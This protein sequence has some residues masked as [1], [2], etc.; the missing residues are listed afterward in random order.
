MHREA[1]SLRRDAPIK[2]IWEDRHRQWLPQ[3]TFGVKPIWKPRCVLTAITI[4]ETVRSGRKNFITV[5]HQLVE[6]PRIENPDGGILIRF[7]VHQREIQGNL[8]V[9]C[10]VEKTSRR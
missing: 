9:F 7:T 1:R 3:A 10:P 5:Q 4:C 8:R 2:L 6:T